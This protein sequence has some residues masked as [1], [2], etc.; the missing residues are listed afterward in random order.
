MI[1][2]YFHKRRSFL[3]ATSLLFMSVMSVGSAQ[4]QGA[5]DWP[6]QPVRIVVPTAAGSGSDAIARA[7]AQKLAEDWKQTV[8]VENRAGASGII[9][10]EAVVR[11]P[12]D[13]YTL[14]M[15]SASP[16]T[17]NPMV[18]KKLSY[19]PR[20]E[21][22][23]VSLVGI[24]QAALLINA[25]VPAN[26]LQEFVALA[27]TKP[28]ALSYGSFGPGSGGHLGVEAFNQAA[29]IEMLHV[30][31]KGTGPALIDLLGGQVTALLTDLATAQTQIAGGK[32]K[33]MAIN[34]PTRSP[35]LPNVPTFT[36]EGYP[37]VEGT[38]A[39]FALFAPAGTPASVI[40]KISVSTITALNSPDIAERFTPMGYSLAGSSP[41]ELASSLEDDATRWRAVIDGLGGLTLD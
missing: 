36:E 4:S 8:I 11:A 35:L 10:V 28:G 16:V 6:N 23:P 15:S 17:I 1:Q 34:G 21:L 20:K 14:L 32:L 25:N 31:Y 40:D 7:L 12:A 24:G 5:A 33:A 9:G 30:P 13:G 29:G 41:G 2:Q 22:A 18:F 19:D 39:R 3:T 38:Y 27:K 37:T 26:N